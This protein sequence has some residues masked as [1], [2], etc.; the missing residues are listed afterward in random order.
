M[1]TSMTGSELTQM[2]LRHHAS[3]TEVPQF[4]I[5]VEVFTTIDY[6]SSSPSPGHQC[7]GYRRLSEG[8]LTILTY[9]DDHPESS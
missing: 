1:S 7:R 4:R 5:R 3:T 8:S 9:L 6:I 2:A